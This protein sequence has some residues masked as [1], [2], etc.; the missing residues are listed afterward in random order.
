MSRKFSVWRMERCCHFVCV[1]DFA[2]HTPMFSMSVASNHHKFIF[3]WWWFSGFIGFLSKRKDERAKTKKRS[4]DEKHTEWIVCDCQNG[5]RPNHVQT[6]IILR[7]LESTLRL[8]S[9][10]NF[11]AS[12]SL[13][14]YSF[15]FFLGSFFHLLYTFYF[16][17]AFLFSLCDRLQKSFHFLNRK[18]MQNSILQ[19]VNCHLTSSIL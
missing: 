4:S 1:C 16:L 14:I 12:N 11:D 2:M 15:F 18:N 6:I 10:Y 9:K 19:T 3:V 7:R 8:W 17:I 13:S 5:I